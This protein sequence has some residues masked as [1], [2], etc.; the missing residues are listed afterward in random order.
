VR[1]TETDFECELGG[2]GSYPGGGITEVQISEEDGGKKAEEEKVGRARGR[3]QGK[4]DGN[5]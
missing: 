3:K 4:K 2:G 1:Q 5:K